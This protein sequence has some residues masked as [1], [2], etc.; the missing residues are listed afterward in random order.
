MQNGSESLTFPVKFPEHCCRTY[1]SSMFPNGKLTLYSYRTM[2]RT[3]LERTLRILYLRNKALFSKCLCAVYIPLRS[4][5]HRTVFLFDL[6]DD[7][8]LFEKLVRGPVQP[9][10]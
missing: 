8:W 7:K 4:L 10:F 1:I 3:L 6:V 2:R 9:C 5:L